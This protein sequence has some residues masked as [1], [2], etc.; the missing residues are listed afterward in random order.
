[1]IYKEGVGFQTHPFFVIALST[2]KI[3]LICSTLK[4]IAVENRNTHGC[5]KRLF[6]LGQKSFAY[7][8]RLLMDSDFFISL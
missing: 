7:I 5:R 8:D 6:L 1:M 2:P 4:S 3:A